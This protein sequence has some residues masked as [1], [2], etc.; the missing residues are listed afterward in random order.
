MDR[1]CLPFLLL[2]GA[3]LLM[4]GIAT[5]KIVAE[6]PTAAVHVEHSAEEPVS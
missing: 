2:I 5:V 4:A 6:S 3:V 1:D